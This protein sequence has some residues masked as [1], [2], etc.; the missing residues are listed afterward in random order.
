[1]CYHPRP[2]LGRGALLQCPQT[3]RTRERFP[4]YFHF[5][6]LLKYGPPLRQSY[7]IIRALC[8]GWFYECKP[9]NWALFWFSKSFLGVIKQFLYGPVHDVMTLLL[10]A[11]MKYLIL[12]HHHHHHH[13]H[14]HL[15]HHRE[16]SGREVTSLVLPMWIRRWSPSVQSCFGC[17]CALPLH[18]LKRNVTCGRRSFDVLL[19]RFR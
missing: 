15:H 4:A 9:Q 3:I 10:F 5:L 8:F 1:M 7:C 6:W 12:E 11:K 16:Q 13:L 14:R 19:S 2:G 18:S 17:H